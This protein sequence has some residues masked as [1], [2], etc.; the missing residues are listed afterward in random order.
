[1]LA[2][3]C[4][5]EGLAGHNP[6]RRLKT[7]F[8]EIRPFWATSAVFCGECLFETACHGFLSSLRLRPATVRGMGFAPHHPIL[9]REFANNARGRFPC[10][11]VR[12]LP[13]C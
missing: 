5:D 7:Y 4:S 2:L 8:D 1:M 13:A 3:F 11:R 12:N 9:R 10:R 6:R